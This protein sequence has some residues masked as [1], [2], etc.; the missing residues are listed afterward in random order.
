MTPVLSEKSDHDAR[1][2]NCAFILHSVLY[3]P[4]ITLQFQFHTLSSH[5]MP[6]STTLSCIHGFQ[7]LSLPDQM[8]IPSDDFTSTLRFA[9]SIYTRAYPVLH[10]PFLRNLTLIRAIQTCPFTRVHHTC[11]S[12]VSF[13]TTIKRHWPI[14]SLTS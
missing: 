13:Q 6:C 2:E 9:N 12:R 7:K 4:P 3:Q 8:S 5:K 10:C 11:P 1:D 14:D